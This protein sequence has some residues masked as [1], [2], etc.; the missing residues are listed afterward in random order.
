MLL[1]A[2]GI[3]SLVPTAKQKKNLVVAFAKRDMI[4]LWED[5]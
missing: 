4:V 2:R 1:A 3:G 5:L